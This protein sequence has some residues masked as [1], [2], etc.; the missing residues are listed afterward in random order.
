M[1]GAVKRCRARAFVASVPSD[2]RRPRARPSGKMAPGL[3]GRRAFSCRE[4]ARG[5]SRSGSRTRGRW[6]AAGAM[7]AGRMKMPAPTTALTIAAVRTGGPVCRRRTA[8]RCTWPLATE[9]CR[10]TQS[11]RSMFLV[12]TI[13]F[14]AV[15]QPPG[16]DPASCWRARADNVEAGGRISTVP[17]GPGR[18][19]FVKDF[20]AVDGRTMRGKINVLVRERV[21]GS[22][23]EEPQRPCLLPKRAAPHVLVHGE[24]EVLCSRYF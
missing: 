14:Q 1:N 13:A 9:G 20:P 23:F 12:V 24:D 2:A 16:D 5:P 6:S 3:R 22:E 19:S 21:S 18:G 17:P 11:G 8:S 10:R 7:A 4:P 15:R